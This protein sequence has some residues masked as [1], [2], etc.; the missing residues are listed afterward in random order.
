MNQ[1]T[2][3]FAQSQYGDQKIIRLQNFYNTIVKL[4]IKKSASTCPNLS[5]FLTTDD[6]VISVK[7]LLKIVDQF[8]DNPYLKS[9]G[10]NKKHF[11][12]LLAKMN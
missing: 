1:T 3:S 6:E 2:T 8:L 11:A 7:T 4:K 12:D 9:F 5:E 10:H